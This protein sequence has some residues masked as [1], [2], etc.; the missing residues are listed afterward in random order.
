VSSVTKHSNVIVSDAQESDFAEI[1][2]IYAPYV[3]KTTV[4]LEDVAPDIEELKARWNKSREKSLPYIVA[5]IDGNVVGYAYAF[6]YRLRTGYRFTV[7]ESVYV[8]EGYKGTGVGHALLDALI[9]ICRAKGY[10]QLV[11]VIAGTDNNTSI[12]FHEKLGFRQA[13]VLQNVG[14]KFDMWV[15][16]VLMQR[17]L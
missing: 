7:E 13:G 8:A 15:D 9:T 11:A 6:P 12:K 1:R 16:T 10:K 4:S 2:R 3:E 14:F 17:D 5:K